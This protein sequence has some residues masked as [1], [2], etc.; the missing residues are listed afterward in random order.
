[1]LEPCE[2]A[3]AESVR[4]SWVT[5]VPCPERLTETDAIQLATNELLDAVDGVAADGLVQ[6]GY[7]LLA[8]TACPA[9]MHPSNRASIASYAFARGL[10][11]VFTALAPDALR[12]RT[13]D[14]AL[15]P[16][17]AN[18]VPCLARALAEASGA[19]GWNDPRA[20][21]STE[22]ADGNQAAVTEQSTP[23]AVGRQPS[24]PF[25]NR[26]RSLRVRFAHACMHR[27]PLALAPS[28]RP[29][30]MGGVA[31]GGAGGM[32]IDVERTL[33]LGTL[34]NR[35]ALVLH[36]S[37]IN[38]SSASVAERHPV[39][40]RTGLE[41]MQ[42]WVRHLPPAATLLMRE[43]ESVDSRTAAGRSRWPKFGGGVSRDADAALRGVRAIGASNAPVSALL[44]VN[45]GLSMATARLP[46][47]AMRPFSYRRLY[48]L[49]AWGNTSAQSATGVPP[50]TPLT[51][52]MQ[53]ID[54]P[55][56]DAA[57]YL[58]FASAEAAQQFELDGARVRGGS[59]VHRLPTAVRRTNAGARASN[60]LDD[61]GRRGGGKG[62]HNP[63]T[64]I[65]AA[66]GWGSFVSSPGDSV[67]QSPLLATLAALSMLAAAYLLL[68][69]LRQRRAEGPT[70]WDRYSHARL[71]AESPT[72][73][74][75]TESKR[76]GRGR[77][78][79]P[80]LP[81]AWAPSPQPSAATP[82]LPPP[83]KCACPSDEDFCVSSTPI[84]FCLRDT[85]NG[86]PGCFAARRGFA[87]SHSFQDVH[88]VIPAHASLI[89][90]DNSQLPSR[91]SGPPLVADS[92]T[93][94]G[95]GGVFLIPMP[96]ASGP[97]DESLEPHRRITPRH[98]Q[99]TCF[100]V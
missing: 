62:H 4:L 96:S 57:L 60:G 81:S 36:A 29:R 16:H 24:Q 23:T 27:R 51:A 67:A 55:P 20:L 68:R 43:S 76:K 52:I 97:D 58:L 9:L 49:S 79:R 90:D 26:L 21:L 33:V 6:A 71:C 35:V 65:A 48:V 37:P 13:L 17:G 78:N 22:A 99:T 19:S 46:L 94:H 30:S 3:S 77:G 34:T 98:D 40:I 56:L 61:Q 75:G 11:L 54:V 100:S 95:E 93:S 82:L 80:R 64:K 72:E 86:D 92:H 84:P 47:D 1:M 7:G 25:L 14:H 83:A 74:P 31:A 41:S 44:L 63:H 18:N 70:R 12:P 73:R 85:G 8:V 38:T 15:F 88:D 2:I 45:K 53:S 69:R 42:V 87:C 39:R 66:P 50:G 59:G 91:G 28:L 5:P 32:P 10:T 89:G